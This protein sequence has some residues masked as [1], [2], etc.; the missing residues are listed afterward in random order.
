MES[1][2]LKINPVP[3]YSL[4]DWDLRVGRMD[5]CYNCEFMEL[6]DEHPTKVGEEYV[7]ERMMCEL[8]SCVIWPMTSVNN[9][10]KSCPLDKWEISNAKWRKLQEKNF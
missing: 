2:R 3:N 1:K 9:D 10:Q 5:T 6:M 7:Y 4:G 8:C